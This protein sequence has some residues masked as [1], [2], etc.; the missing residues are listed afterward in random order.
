LLLLCCQ[1]NS[2]SLCVSACIAV[3][4]FWQLDHQPSRPHTV[5]MCSI[6][7]TVCLRS[8]LS[9]CNRPHSCHCTRCVCCVRRCTHCWHVHES[10]GLSIDSMSCRSPL[11]IFGAAG[12][13]SGG[14]HEANL[15]N[16]SKSSQPT[17][18][19]VRHFTKTQSYLSKA[20][21]RASDK[22]HGCRQHLNQEVQQA[23]R[24]CSS[25]IQSTMVD[26]R[27]TSCYPVSF[28]AS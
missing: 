26:T 6:V 20:V 2:L 24:P 10:Q 28:S 12:S 15:S 1:A 25:S 16:T 9:P 23:A 5:L 8:R 19:Q 22:C 13:S 4:S 11:R 7:R 27:Y 18:K 14:K 3:C 17:S 21:G